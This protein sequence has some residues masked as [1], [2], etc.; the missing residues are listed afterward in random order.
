M[1]GDE[2]EREEIQFSCWYIY[3]NVIVWELNMGVKDLGDMRG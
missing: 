2:E 1:R 3:Q